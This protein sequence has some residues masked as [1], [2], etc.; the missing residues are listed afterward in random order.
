MAFALGS[1]E[2]LANVALL[3]PLTF[4]ATL[5]IGLDAL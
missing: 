5:T 3:L 4:F 1:V 2:L